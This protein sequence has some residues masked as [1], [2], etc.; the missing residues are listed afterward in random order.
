MISIL[1]SNIYNTVNSMYLLIWAD[2]D[3]FK[4]SKISNCSCFYYYLFLLIYIIIP[5]FFHFNNLIFCLFFS[6]K[7]IPEPYCKEFCN[8]YFSHRCQF[9]VFPTNNADL[10]DAGRFFYKHNCNLCEYPA[11]KIQIKHGTTYF[12]QWEF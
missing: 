3:R 7:F 4:I 8:S 2:K 5:N 1:I 10:I 11:Y 9:Q 12:H 6:D